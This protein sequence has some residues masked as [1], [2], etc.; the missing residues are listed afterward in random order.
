ML[1]Y[2]YLVQSILVA[3]I[4]VWISKS[5]VWFAFVSVNIIL[6]ENVNCFC[7]FDSDVLD[8]N[9]LCHFIILKTRKRCLIFIRFWN[10]KKIN[11]PKVKLLNS[12]HNLDENYEFHTQHIL[13]CFAWM[14]AL[15]NSLDCYYSIVQCF[16]LFWLSNKNPFAAIIHRNVS[17]SLYV[18]TV[19]Y[20]CCGWWVIIWFTHIH[21]LNLK[22]NVDFFSCCYI[23]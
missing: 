4:H 16:L 10:K 6:M 17:V 22:K 1:F 18:F 13:T 21:S 7:N 14:F 11:E 15:S 20:C 2:I 5:H 9:S 8:M 12:S 19:G 3:W 23:M